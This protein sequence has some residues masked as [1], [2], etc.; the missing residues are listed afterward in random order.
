MDVKRLTATV[1]DANSNH[2]YEVRV[3]F[4]DNDGCVLT[5]KPRVMLWRDGM[6]FAASE[7]SVTLKG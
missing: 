7:I 6:A 3:D 2:Q 4:M 5:C 1:R